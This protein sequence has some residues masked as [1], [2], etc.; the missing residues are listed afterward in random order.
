MMFSMTSFGE[1]VPIEGDIRVRRFMDLRMGNF[2]DADGKHWNIWG[3]A[4]NEARG[5]VHGVAWAV[6]AGEVHPY[7]TDTSSGYFGLVSQSWKPYRV[8]VSP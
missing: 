8:V 5:R 6:P 4:G 1:K 2:V 3:Y 7:Y